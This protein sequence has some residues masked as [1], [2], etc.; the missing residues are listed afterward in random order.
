MFVNNFIDDVKTNVTDLY[1]RDLRF[2]LFICCVCE[3][4]CDCVLVCVCVCERERE[5]ES[6]CVCV[7]VCVCEGMCEFGVVIYVAIEKIHSF[8]VFRLPLTS[9][10]FLTKCLEMN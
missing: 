3:C 5:R 1:S 10:Y 7:C 8:Y 2:Y 6:V 9:Y 4:D